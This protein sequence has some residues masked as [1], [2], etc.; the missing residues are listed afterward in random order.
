MTEDLLTGLLNKKLNA[1][2][3]RKCQI[4]GNRPN[5]S[6][7]REEIR[8]LAGLL[9]DYEMT[10]TAVNPFFNAQVCAGGLALEELDEHMQI[11]RFPGL[12]MTGELLDADGI[13]G[14]YN[15]HWAFAT[16]TIAGKAIRG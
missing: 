13:C 4:R 1:V 7:T 16:G 6:L 11:R 8:Q 12:Y 9:K 2:L 3:L 10:I 14:G 5:Q 15:L